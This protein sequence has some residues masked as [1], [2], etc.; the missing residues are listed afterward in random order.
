MS[1]SCCYEGDIDADW[2]TERKANKAHQCD[3]C[4]ETINKRDLYT[5]Y[6]SVAYGEFLNHKTCEACTDLGDS[7]A[8]QGFCWE[9]GCLR[10]AHQEYI[11][12]YAPQ[13]LNTGK[14]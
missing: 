12:E 10:Q 5:I 8:A 3:E 13:K 1:L 14:Q 6:S 4:C 9:L 2:T 7:M 11:Q